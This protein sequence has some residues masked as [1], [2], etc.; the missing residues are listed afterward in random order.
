MIFIFKNIKLII[1]LICVALNNNFSL[2]LFYSINLICVSIYI[3]V[4]MNEK[5]YLNKQI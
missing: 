2:F 3:I 4:R 1:F 5:N